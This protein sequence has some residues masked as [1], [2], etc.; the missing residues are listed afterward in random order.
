MN[1]AT[2]IG[3]YAAITKELGRDL[4]FPGSER[5]YMGFDCFTDAK[6]HAE[7]CMWA[8]GEEKTKNQA[9]NVVNGDVESWQSLWP[10][11]ARR[12]GMKVKEDQFEGT[13]GYEGRTELEEPV[14]VRTVEGEMGVKGR[15]G[16]SVLEQRVN[17]EGWSQSEEVKKAW[18]RLVER[19][20]LERDGLEKATWAFANFVLGRN[21]D[22]V[23]SM[24]K[25]R[26]AGWNGYRD[27]WKA[28]SDVF[29][30]LEA[31]NVLPKV[32]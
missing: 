19:E 12:F 17:L 11:V 21:Y 26:E 15:V 16:G 3:I 28:F 5:F 4:A 20:G 14:P 8:V 29:G 32:H 25:A 24:G 1:L 9:F 18:G 31:A 27:T 6:L 7:F 10:R 13:T 30:E 22:V 23:I 2:T